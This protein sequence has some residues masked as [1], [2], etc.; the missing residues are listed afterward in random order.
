MDRT[1][2]ITGTR[3]TTTARATTSSTNKEEGTSNCGLEEDDFL[4]DD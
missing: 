3:T 4:E 2:V 1:K